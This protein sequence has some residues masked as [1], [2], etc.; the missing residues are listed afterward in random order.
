[1]ICK[2]KVPNWMETLIILV[3]SERYANYMNAVPLQ[4]VRRVAIMKSQSIIE[5][6]IPAGLEQPAGEK[7]E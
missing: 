7:E 3:E 6:N 5:Q 4:Y 2:K 1:M